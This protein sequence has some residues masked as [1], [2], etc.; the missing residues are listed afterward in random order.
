MR[1]P[2]P[3]T[4]S[5][6]NLPEAVKKLPKDKKAQWIA[7][8]NN[9]IKEYKGDEGKSFAAAW[10]AIKKDDNIEKV[11]ARHSRREMELMRKIIDM[12]K[13][14]MGEEQAEVETEKK[15]IRPEVGGG[16][17]VSQMPAGDFVFSATRTFP[18]SNASDVMDA[19][20]SFGRSRY[21]NQFAAFKRRLIAICRRK[22]FMD[23]LPEDWKKELKKSVD[24]EELTNDVRESFRHMFA[25]QFEYPEP[26]AYPYPVKVLDDGVICS[27]GDTFYKIPYEK[28]NDGVSFG[29]RDQWQVVE[30]TWTP[31]S[32]LEGTEKSWEAEIIKSD[33][34]HLIY[35]VVM[36]PEPFTDTQGDT[37]TESEI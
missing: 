9:C 35:G 31:V 12:V 7:V 25:P 8:F 24:L 30:W 28:S 15:D 36:K 26:E 4:E 5:S 29:S 17:D 1:W 23:A 11:G 37:A 34:K 27:W 22:G 20:H 2:M 13:E 19:V 16:V 3:Y 6:D 10:A 32:D 33:D 18:I 21:R 14:V